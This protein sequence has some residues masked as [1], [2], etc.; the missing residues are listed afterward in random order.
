ME[1]ASDRKTRRVTEEELRGVTAVIMA[2]GEGRRLYP[3]TADLPKPL[4]PVGGRPVL[5]HVFDNLLR[6]GFREAALT[7]RYRAEDIINR[8]GK[9]YRGLALSYIT[10]K[11]P[12]GTAG[13]VAAAVRR[14]D[15]ARGGIGRQS[16][17][18][19]EMGT[20]EDAAGNG[21]VLILSGDAVSDVDLG[22]VLRFH[23]EKGAE[24]TLVLFSAED[25]LSFGITV[26]APDGRVTGFVEKPSWPG[27]VS[28]TVNTGIYIINRELLRR[29]PD[30]ES[31]DF[32]KQFFPRLIK[33]GRRVFGF[34]HRGYWCDI[35]SPES[36]IDCNMLFSGGKTVVGHGCSIKGG[37]ISRS[38]LSDGVTVGEGCEI[39]SAVIC[40]GASLGRGCRVGKYAVIGS[41]A[42][43][44]DGAVVGAYATVGPGKVLTA[45]EERPFSDAV[46]WAGN[47]LEVRGGFDSLLRF[48]RMLA[49]ALCAGAEEVCAVVSPADDRTLSMALAAGF[50]EGGA[51]VFEER[52]NEAQASFLASENRLPLCAFIALLG[53]GRYSVSLFGPDGAFPGPDFER[54]LRALIRAG[55]APGAPGGK[56]VGSGERGELSVRYAKTLSD[57]LGTLDGF[58]VYCEGEE[59][60]TGTLFRR[61]AGSGP[62]DHKE[63]RRVSIRFDSGQTLR[64]SRGDARELPGSGAGSYPGFFISDGS[65]SADYPHTAAVLLTHLSDTSSLPLRLEDQAFAAAWMLRLLADTG[66]PLSVLL[67]ALPRFAMLERTVFAT[68]RVKSRAMS[69]ADRSAPPLREGVTYTFDGLGSAVVIPERGDSLRII[70]RGASA[71]AAEEIFGLS[72]KMIDRIR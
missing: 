18:E 9:N 40:S 60:E 19:T 64:G 2:G 37:T 58:T 7:L 39:A 29:I 4:V 44:R 70:A 33:E 61:E 36:Y 30:G 16:G 48:G 12:L 3:L 10:E 22:E 69:F 1:R 14:Q 31:C 46:R 68:P 8:Y 21:E 53:E 57:V 11:E 67:A 45:G 26:C 6:G 35:G 5:E 24:A 52:G 71:E 54:K 13:G 41:G 63:K 25:P 23:R 51:K 56:V 34:P 47:R 42:E 50:A 55:D 28:D 15:E 66:K 62:D 59:S 65:A 17:E 38:V 43:L 27:A 32:G 49:A 72:K 20:G